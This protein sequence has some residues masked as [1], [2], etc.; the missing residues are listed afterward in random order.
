MAQPLV[1]SVTQ[2]RMS[3]V[4]Q[5]SAAPSEQPVPGVVPATGHLQAAAPGA[6]W[7]VLDPGQALAP[8]ATKQVGVLLS[9]AQLAT[10]VVLWQKVPSWACVQVLS[11]VQ[12][13]EG[14]VP[15]QLVCAGQVAV[16][17]MVKQPWASAAQVTRL[18]VPL[19]KV[20][21][22]VHPAGGALQVQTPAPVQ[23]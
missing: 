9:A 16:P 10:L 20:P 7:Q 21:A 15:L 3:S 19:Q 2:L 12:A 1:L 6:P 8:V 23:V 11:Q 22:A 13:A 14:R 5:M 4:E 18:P 17:E